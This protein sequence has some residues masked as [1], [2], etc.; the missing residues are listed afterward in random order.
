MADID[1]LTQMP[2]YFVADSELKLLLHSGCNRFDFLKQDN[3]F[4]QLIDHLRSSDVCK[5]FNFDYYT[6]DEFNNFTTGL[7]RKNNIELSVFHINIRSLNANHRKLSLYLD[8]LCVKFDVIVVSEIWKN[9][10]QFYTNI[11]PGYTFYYDVPILANVG[12]VGVFVND[13]LFHTENTTLKISSCDSSRVENVWVEIIK[14]RTKY[15]IGGIYRQP[16]KDVT[17]FYN[18]LDATVCR[19]SGKNTPCII[20][21]DF[22]IDVQKYSVNKPTA[23]YVDSV[24]LR[25]CAQLLLTAYCVT[26][27]CLLSFC[28]QE[29]LQL[30]QL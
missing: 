27:C 18:Q 19:I 16:N 12:G 29:L 6:E 7:V 20:A 21:G 30:L 2:F 23:N 14:N 9:N 1:L 22:N 17:L 28:R 26:T 25:R 10:L 5:E 8:L 11:L 3:D 24:L 15:I 13:T 4:L